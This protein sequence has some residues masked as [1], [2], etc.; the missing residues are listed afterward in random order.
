MGFPIRKK[1]SEIRPSKQ[2]VFIV[3]GK[4][5]TDY[6]GTIFAIC[7]SSVKGVHGSRIYRSTCCFQVA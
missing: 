7:S 2:Q 3:Y 6:E 1:K 5:E 4:P